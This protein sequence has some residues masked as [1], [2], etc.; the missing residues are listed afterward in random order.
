M[1][2]RI[3]LFNPLA[4]RSNDALTSGP[5]SR[6]EA[7]RTTV[8]RVP[9]RKPPDKLRRSHRSVASLKPLIRGPLLALAHT[10]IFLFAY[11]MSFGLRFDFAVPPEWAKCCWS[12]LPWVLLVK[13]VLFSYCGQF[14]GWWRYVTMADLAVLLKAATFSL[15]AMIVVDRF[16]AEPH[17]HIPRSILILDFLLSVVCVGGLR[18]SWRL[19]TELQLLGSGNTHRREAL[20]VGSD[21]T[22]GLLAHQMQSMPQS[23]FCI[24][25]LLDV[26]PI[27]T[28]SRQGRIPI[29]GTPADVGTVA[30]QYGLSDVFAI[31]GDLPGQQLR[32]LMSAC[33]AA[34]L[35]LKIV[36]RPE[37]L[38]HGTARVPTRDIEINDLLRRDPVQL[39]SQSIGT[40]LKGKTIL[41][42]GAGGSIGSE[43]CRQVIKFEPRALILVG[44]GEN[45]IFYIE[46]ELVALGTSTRLT[47][48][49]GDI[50]DEGRIRQIFDEFHPDVIFHAAAH[51]HVPLME[52]NVGEAVKNNVGGTRCIADL[53]DEF[54][55]QCM[56]LISSDKAVNP[57]NVMGATKN[58]AERYVMALA[59]KSTTRYLVTRFGNVLGSAGSVV[60]LFQEQ[61]RQG[62]PITVTD[63]RMT[64]YFM[65]IPEASQLVLQAAAIGRGGEIFVL[66]MGEPVEIVNLA[67]D[68]IRL[69][70][71][72]ENSIEIVC[73]GIRPGE[74][75]HEEPYFN[76][77]D[78][79]STSHDKLRV[80]CH[81]LEDL[82]AV[83]DTVCELLEMADGP[84]DRLLHHLQ[85]VIPEYRASVQK[86]RGVAHER[87]LSFK[88]VET[89]H[90]GQRGT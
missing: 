60:P 67:R 12:N 14:H 16:A 42:T 36:P 3:N 11:L 30:R 90:N 71:L 72:P 38:F 55:V 41:V 9:Y 85:E 40:L 48:R 27:K 70:G 59:E 44:K 35:T 83:N 74:K 1:R 23:Q 86:Q 63:R 52:A 75:L 62:G 68:M 19:L 43:I 89:A 66:E 84:Q 24:R 73:S 28:G 88:L 39:D 78:T 26:D 50:T 21:H 77:H 18:A 8:E 5:A 76:G 80:A 64:R 17:F 15:I 54:K 25:G 6:L 58:L 22:A 56:V 57:A 53:A 47:P 32:S 65:T 37:E 81:G 49:I 4:Y 20:M 34:G 87:Q 79:I 7:D 10:A 33:E 13:L 2:A 31:A 69:S 45:R 61:I 51:K 82:H 46:R 29:L